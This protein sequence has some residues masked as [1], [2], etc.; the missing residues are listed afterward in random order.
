[1]DILPRVIIRIKAEHVVAQQ[2]SRDHGFGVKRTNGVVNRAGNQRAVGLA[3]DFHEALGTERDRAAVVKPQASGVFLDRRTSTTTC[4]LANRRTSMPRL[5]SPMH[6]CVVPFQLEL[7][8]Q[9][10]SRAN[11]AAV[12]DKSHS[13]LVSRLFSRSVAQAPMLLRR[14]TVGAIVLQPIVTVGPRVGSNPGLRHGRRLQGPLCLPKRDR[15]S[16]A[17]VLRREN[18][19]PRSNCSQFREWRLKPAA[20]GA[21]VRTGA[22]NKKGSI[23]A[24]QLGLSRFLELVLQVSGALLQWQSE[25]G[26]LSRGFTS[27]RFKSQCAIHNARGRRKRARRQLRPPFQLQLQWSARSLAL[28]PQ[29]PGALLHWESKPGSLPGGSSISRLRR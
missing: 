13:R 10:R 18:G 9:L 1:M 15:R 22:C 16:V 21:C 5:I 27:S 24:K 20:S 25:P 7:F 8:W 29:V 14:Q 23:D 12:F 2:L 3:C 28:V 6:A 19:K 11:Q 17:P 26:S 4:K